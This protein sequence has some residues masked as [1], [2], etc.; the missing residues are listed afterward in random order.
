MG[1]LVLALAYERVVNAG[2]EEDAPAASSEAETPSEPE[3][4]S[5]IRTDNPET[6]EELDDAPVIGEALEFLADAEEG[7]TENLPASEDPLNIFESDEV[8]IDQALAPPIETDDELTVPQP[9]LETA[10]LDAPAASET[11]SA[12]PEN[13][14]DVSSGGEVQ[15]VSAP[16]VVVQDEVEN[17]SRILPDGVVFDEAERP[18]TYRRSGRRIQLP[19][20]SLRLPYRE[21][22]AAWISSAVEPAYPEACA[23]SAAETET[24][25][26]RFRINNLGRAD[27]PKAALATNACFNRAAVAAVRSSRFRVR[28]PPGFFL[29]GSTFLVSYEFVKNGDS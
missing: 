21:M 28:P 14:D 24:V 2:D 23:A 29:G 4:V 3:E 12:P 11:P 22:P 10:A 16:A 15:P 19:D 26:V 13:S 17:A 27:S 1:L 6:D 9:P 8:I 18:F 5:A 25:V 20:G 7:P